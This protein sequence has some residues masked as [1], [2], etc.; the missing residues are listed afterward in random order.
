MDYE[1]LPDDSSISFLSLHDSPFFSQSFSQGHNSISQ[2]G[3]V[4]DGYCSF[5]YCI[6]MQHVQVSDM[7]RFQAFSKMKSWRIYF[8]YSPVLPTEDKLKL[9]GVD[10]A[11]G[12]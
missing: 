6:L 11:L 4:Q 3:N 5:S 10:I 2:C 8:M 9:W 12:N 7:L 1:E